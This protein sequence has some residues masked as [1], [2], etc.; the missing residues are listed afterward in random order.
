MQVKRIELA[1]AMAA[2]LA[3]SCEH[4]ST[5]GPDKKW[6]CALAT[7]DNPEYSVTLGCKDD[8]TAL[9]SEPLD[10]SIPGA[11]SVR[12]AGPTR[13]TTNSPSNTSPATASR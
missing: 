1:A 9:S 13:S 11:T 10:A 3:L 2:L 12:T 5:P 4:A 7:V 6:E 8:F